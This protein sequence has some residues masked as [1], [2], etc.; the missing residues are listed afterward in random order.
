MM[1]AA[2]PRAPS[3]AGSVTHAIGSSESWRDEQRRTFTR[4]W[5]SHLFEH[6]LHVHD[7]ATDLHSGVL[8]IKLLEIL[9]DEKVEH[10]VESPKSHFQA[11]ENHTIFLNDLKAKS[12]KL[13]N[14]IFR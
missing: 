6:G 9:S 12:I 10:C 4:W 7:L 13:I 2:V 5:N 8:P 1:E 3:R 14:K 11:L